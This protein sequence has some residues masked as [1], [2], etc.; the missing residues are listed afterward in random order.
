QAP[1]LWMLDLSAPETG[2]FT[3][4]GLDIDFRLLVLLMG[5]SMFL[6]QKMTPAAGDPTQQKMMLFMPIIFT[7]MFYTFPS[8]LVVYWFTN[9]ILSII[10]QYFALRGGK[11]PKA[12]PVERAPSVE[13]PKAAAEKPGPAKTKAKTQKTKSKKPKA[14]A[15]KN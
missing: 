6:Q 12:A 14:R 9:N 1:F 3:I 13:R 4:P 11:R 15:G 8:G 7:F 5:G 10:Q 2:I